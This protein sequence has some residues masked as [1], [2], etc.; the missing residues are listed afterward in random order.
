MNSPPDALSA[1]AMVSASDGWAVGSSEEYSTGNIL[2]YT[3]GQWTAIQ[4]PPNTTLSA[5]AMVSASD[6]WAVG[7]EVILHYTGGQW[8]QL[9]GSNWGVL[10]SVAMVSATD[11]WVVGWSGTILHYR[12]GT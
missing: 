6:G 1:V 11:G 4:A 9:A 12:S 7:D 3:G 2:H 5:V 10:A 8:T